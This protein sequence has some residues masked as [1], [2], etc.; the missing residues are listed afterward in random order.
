MYL[1]T[2]VYYNINNEIFWLSFS[3]CLQPLWALKHY[4]YTYRQTYDVRRFVKNFW[5]ITCF[6]G[7]TYKFFRHRD[8]RNKSENCI[9]LNRES[10]FCHM[11]CNAIHQLSYNG[12]ITSSKLQ[13][14][15]WGVIVEC[16]LEENA[17]AHHY[18]P[19][20]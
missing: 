11:V 12:L 13:R 20:T 10:M 6:N 7:S 14:A 2:Y 5:T 3:C 4:I 16:V 17:F 18:M 1:H 19:R 8:M 9:S 15:A